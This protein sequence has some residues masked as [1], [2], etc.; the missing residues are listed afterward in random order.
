MRDWSTFT[1]RITIASDARALYNC[2]AVPAEIER[3]FLASAEYR[4][5]DSVIRG[6]TERVSAGDL[7]GWR[8]H[9]YSNGAA[10]SGKILTANGHN[11]FSFTFTEGCFVDVEIKSELG[12]KVVELTQRKIAIDEARSVY[13]ACSEGWTFYLSNLKSILEGGVDLRN[14]NPKLKSVINS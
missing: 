1:K 13:L 7:Y 2:W 6:R 4:S 5:P 10:E 11:F 9:G 12:E 8:W 3:W 14:K